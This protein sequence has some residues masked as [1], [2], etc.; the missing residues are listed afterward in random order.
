MP[1]AQNYDSLVIGTGQAGPSLAA[2]LA[3]SGQKVAIIE[4][5]LFGGTCVNTGCIP[6]KTMVASARAAHVARR[7]SDFGVVIH[8]PV[9]VDMKKVKQRKDQVSGASR[10]SVEQWLRNT[11]NVTVYTGH[12][13]FQ[14]DHEVRISGPEEA[15]VKADRIFVNTGGRADV[16]PLDGITQVPYL[17][18]SSMME[19]DFLPDHL[20]IIG[21]SYIGL[22]FAQMFRRFGSEVTVI[23]RKPRLI[24]GED[25]ETSEA[26]RQILVGEGINVRLRAE[27]IALSQTS[28]GGVQ[29]HA[30][31]EEGAPVTHGS[32]ILIATGR[33]PNTDD[34]GLEN[35]SVQRDKRGYIQVDEQL[36]TTAPGVWALGDCNG[37]GA[38]THTSYNDTRS[39]QPICSTGITEGSATAFPHML[40][41]SILRWEEQE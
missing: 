3:G 26:I 28:D 9:R 1:E 37:K 41:I 13:R 15:L 21:G 38:F 7:A 17:T 36:R 39:S 11:P 19:V 22:E 40:C 31:C 33:R 12:A 10:T 20:I 18:N 30:T 6:T 35:T 25:E 14:S 2:K 4:R 27:C 32:H 34:L 24:S 29:A 16:P 5:K 8:G 23:E